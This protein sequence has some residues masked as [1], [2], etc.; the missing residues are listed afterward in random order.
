MA[1]SIG[2]GRV[3]GLRITGDMPAEGTE[4]LPTL[5]SLFS[6][7]VTIPSTTPSHHYTGP[8]DHGLEPLELRAEIKLSS[9]S[10]NHLRYF[11][12]ER[13]LASRGNKYYRVKLQLIRSEK[14]LPKRFRMK[15]TGSSKMP[16]MYTFVQHLLS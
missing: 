2:K 7:V 13:M 12:T 15:K 14:G 11:V 4:G 10:T 9:R 3:G 6:L 5:F 16:I 1:S 8:A